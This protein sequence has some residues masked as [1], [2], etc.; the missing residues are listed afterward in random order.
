G[1]IWTA[2]EEQEPLAKGDHLLKVTA[3]HPEGIDSIKILANGIVVSEKACAQ[4]PEKFGPECTP[5][6]D[7]WLVGTYELPPG[8]LNLEVI[9]TDSKGRSESERFWVQVPY[10]PPPSPEEEQTPRARDILEFR[11]DYGLEVVFPVAN[12]SQLHERVLNLIGAWGNPNT[13]AGAVARASWERWGVP[14]RPE[15]VAE[16]EYREEYMAVNIPI[17][18]AWATQN[19]PSTYA[20]YYVDHA[21]GGI[22]HVGFTQDQSGALAQLAQQP[23]ILAPGRLAAYAV[24]P[25]TARPSLQTTFEQAEAAWDSDSTLGSLVTGMG[26]DERSNTVEV[27]GTDPALIEGR[28]KLLLGSGAPIRAVY[29]PIGQEFM[30]RD[31][32]DGR[33]HAGD[34]TYRKKG[35]GAIGSCT[36]GFGAWDRIGTKPNGESEIAP[37]LMT[38]AHCGDP[39][40][41][42]YRAKSN[43]EGAVNLD[44]LT[45]IGHVARTAFVN[46]GAP[47]ETDA[48]LVKLNG[49]GL[50]PRYIHMPGKNPKPVEEPGRPYPGETLCFS[51]PGG[52]VS[53]HPCGEYMG[54]RVR[55]TPNKRIVM[56][57]RFVGMPGDSG[58]PVW[59]PRL[60]KSVGIILGGP[61]DG[62]GRFKGWVTP[63][64]V[65]RNHEFHAGKVPGALNAPGLGTFHLAVPGG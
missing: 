40:Q 30:A 20:G 54:T 28:L 47:F 56:V 13:P 43:S 14:L 8:V 21:A 44:T 37:F 52:D 60:Q 41:L 27:T 39:G 24:P 33:I 34:K 58:G 48:A 6:E 5:G 3:D 42:F 10:T 2:W 17:I 29:E 25:T 12:E 46:D 23:G 16:M 65:P 4:D 51:A 9:I 18:E 7:E 32:I 55:K 59:S 35:G 63:L 49:G 62:Q 53:K 38:A 22:L 1:S 36:A 19:R 31:H 50:M 26:I 45:K 57:A 11:E 64:L 15:D 61:N